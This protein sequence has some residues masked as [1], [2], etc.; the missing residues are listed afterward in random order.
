MVDIVQQIRNQLSISKSVVCDDFNSLGYHEIGN[1]IEENGNVNHS[2]DAIAVRNRLPEALQV[3]DHL[4]N[5]QNF[6]VLNGTLQSNHAIE[7]IPRF[8]ENLKS[9]PITDVIK[10]DGMSA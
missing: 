9:F 3:I 1:L 2:F 10:R 5:R 7:S 4:V 8:C 6:L